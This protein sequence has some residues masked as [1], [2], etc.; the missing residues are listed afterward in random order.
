MWKAYVSLFGFLFDNLDLKIG[1][2]RISWDTADKLN[3][4][5]NLNPK[6]FSDL[7]NFAEKIPSWAVKASYDLGDYNLT[8]VWLLNFEHVLLPRNGTS[9]FLGDVLTSFSSILNIK[10]PIHLFHRCLF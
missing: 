3:Q 6:D 7:N 9:L 1:K 10:L 5:D 4:T 2:Q 8:A